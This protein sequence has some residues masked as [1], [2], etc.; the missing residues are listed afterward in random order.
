[1]VLSLCQ[2]TPL[3]SAQQARAWRVKVTV[4]ALTA[5]VCDQSLRVWVHR[6]PAGP[7]SHLAA[8]DVAKA[9]SFPSYIL[10]W[11]AGALSG[12]IRFPFKNF[13]MTALVYKSSQSP[14]ERVLLCFVT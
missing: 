5:W 14:E 10:S 7:S 3:L 1:M 8:H 6:P 4:G 12:D 9:C 2:S 11:Q 13:P